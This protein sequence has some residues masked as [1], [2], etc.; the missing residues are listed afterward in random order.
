[1]KKMTFL[2]F[3]GVALFG[4][5]NPAEAKQGLAS[6][7]SVEVIGGY[8]KFPGELVEMDRSIVEHPPHMAGY[9]QGLRGNY[10][11]N[12]NWL[13]GAAWL[14]MSS[15]GGGNWARND[16]AETLARN[17]VTGVITGVTNMELRG[18]VLEAEHRF[19][20]KKDPVRPYARFGAGAGELTV[21]FRGK[22]VGTETVS[23]FGFPV[24]EDARDRVKR[25]IPLVSAE[26]GLRFLLTKHLNLTMAGYWNTG[27][28]A[29]VGAGWKF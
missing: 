2:A 6:R 5:M 20:R 29:L 14:R 28:G 13:V 19:F 7:L 16:T 18:V 26:L 21:D 23:G 4:S 10:Q 17:N 12:D 24:E 25:T 1:M 3:C 8:Y 27:Y 9:L 22:F 11:L 15:S